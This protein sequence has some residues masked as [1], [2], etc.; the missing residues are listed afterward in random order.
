MPRWSRHHPLRLATVGALIATF[1]VI[2]P[3][4]T[5]HAAAGSAYVRVNQLGYSSPSKRAYLM[6]STAETGATF[7]VKNSGG[8]TVYSAAV[9]ASLGSWS[10]GYPDVYALDFDS[11]TAP[12]TYTIVVTGPVAASSPA[13]RV[14]TAANVYG[15]AMANAVSFYQNQRDGANYLPSAL[16][17]APAHLNDV[18]AM[19]Y[20]TPHAR[21]SGGFSGDLTSL[22]VTIDASGGWWDAGDYLK[23]LQTDQLHRRH[24][25]RRRPGLPDP[26]RSRVQR[27]GPFWHRLAAADV[28]RLHKD[29]VLPGRHRRRQRQDRRRPR[30]LAAAAGRRQL[31]RHRDRRSLHTQPAGVPSQLTGRLDQ[32]EPRRSRGGRAGD[33][34]PGLPHQRSVVREQVPALRRARLR[35]REHRADRASA[36][37]HPVQLLS[38]DRVARRPR[39]RRHRAQPRTRRRVAAGRPATQ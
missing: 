9:G 2:A 35:S 26:D 4:T 22:G 39:T 10:S 21:S 3:G 19:T 33:V 38:G 24:H 28:E 1:A 29:A 15:T 32:P 17:T 20:A 16:R 36:H 12:G 11:V 34:L 13:L 25:A 7:V 30:H 31:R 37:R 5:A 14:D 8:S 27:R 23:F 6:S 18:T